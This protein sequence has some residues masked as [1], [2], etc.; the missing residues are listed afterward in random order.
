MVDFSALRARRDAAIEVL[1]LAVQA[2]FGAGGLF[3][4]RGYRSPCYCACPAG[5]CEHVWDGPNADIRD[6]EGAFLGAEATCSRCRLGAMT[7]D[8]MVDC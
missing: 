2:R 6:D 4:C 8:L 1:A 5:P 3:H 7:H